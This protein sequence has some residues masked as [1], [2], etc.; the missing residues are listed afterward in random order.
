MSL[1]KA[2]DLVTVNTRAY[3]P[4]YFDHNGAYKVLSVEGAWAMVRCKTGTAMNC[5][6]VEL[7]NVTPVPEKRL[8]TAEYIKTIGT[9]VCSAPLKNIRSLSEEIAA[10]PTLGVKF[11][12]DKPKWSLLP[13]G[14]MSQVVEVLTFGA[15]KYS[16]DNWMHVDP[17][18]Y[19]DALFRHIDA[20]RNGEKLDAESGKHHLAHALCCLIYMLWHDDNP[21]KVA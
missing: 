11:D 1:I 3:G 21:K 6:L 9:D 18:R 19:Y 10:L 13:R 15:K 17:A 4:L 5:K 16:P 8:T 12:N 20:W 7:T 2:G 14:V